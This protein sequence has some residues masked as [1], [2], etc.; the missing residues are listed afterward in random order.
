M[1][2]PTLVVSNIQELQATCKQRLATLFSLY[3]PGIPSL[4]L[5]NMMEYALAPNGK[6]VRPL[7]VYATGI[8]FNAPADYLDIPASAVELIHTYS[9]IHDDLPC[10]DNADLRRGQASM[11]KKFGDGMAVL[12]GDA[13]HT[14]AMQ[15]L[16]A[17][18]SSLRAPRRLQMIKILAEACGPFGMA[19]GQALDLTAVQDHCTLSPDLLI[20]IYR[21]K[22][23]ALLSA[24]IELGWLCSPDEDEMNLQSLKDFGHCLG[25]AFQIQDDLIDIETP[26]HLSGKPQGADARLHKYTYPHFHGLNAAKEKVQRLYEE[27]F[28]CINRFGHQV[29]LL[30]DLAEMLL[31]RKM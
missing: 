5:K 24:C 26:S 19:A 6:Y 7:L 8:C 3:L 4:S 11:H 25:L 20:D 18:P 12:A 31:Q 23:G 1:K 15:L 10:M 21:F 29:Q 22:T 2:A 30:R 13:L 9:L 16:A 17:H 27:A 28:E 14:F